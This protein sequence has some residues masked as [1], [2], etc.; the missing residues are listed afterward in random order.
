MHFLFKARGR[1]SRA[2]RA[3]CAS[4]REGTD[5]LKGGHRTAA[6]ITGSVSRI[7]MPLLGVHSLAR[8]F[9]SRV[10]RALRCAPQSQRFERVCLLRRAAERE[11]SELGYHRFFPSPASASVWRARLLRLDE[12]S[13]RLW[14]MESRL[15]P[16]RPVVSPGI[17]AFLA[18]LTSPKIKPAEAG[19]PYPW[20][21]PA[22]GATA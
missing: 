11:I 19:T 22:R 20:A 12:R 6:R 1:S 15:H 14:G 2:R 13:K 18:G 4:L 5:T 8:I 10:G 7:G 9:H 3:C 16:A 17:F 21:F